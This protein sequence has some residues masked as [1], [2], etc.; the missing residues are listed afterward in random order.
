VAPYYRDIIRLLKAWRNK[1]MFPVSSYALEL[2]VIEASKSGP[3]TG[4]LEKL[5]LHTLKS[6]IASLRANKPLMDHV[7]ALETRDHLRPETKNQLA[8][9][10]SKLLKKMETADHAGLTMEFLQ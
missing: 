9:H 3:P 2:L 4:S 1:A 10:F 7:A 5:L 6:S 8:L